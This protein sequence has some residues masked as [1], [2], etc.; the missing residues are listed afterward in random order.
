MFTKTQLLKT[1]KANGFKGTDEQAA[2]WIKKN[3]DIRDADGNAVDVDA[4]FARKT[5]TVTADA[6]EVVKV[7]DG[8]T[9]AEGEMETES[10]AK[11]ITDDEAAD[12]KRLKAKETAELRAKNAGSTGA[13]VAKGAA[14]ERF[15][16]GNTATKAYNRKAKSGRDTA[17]PIL[18]AFSDADTAH[19]FGEWVQSDVLRTKTSHVTASNTLGGALVP[20][21]F[22]PDLIDLKEQYGVARKLVPFIQISGHEAVLPRR[23]S[24][25]TVYSPQEGSAIT[26]SNM[27]FDNVTVN[28][29]EMAVLASASKALVQESAI[30]IG[31]TVANN[32]AW[33]FSE[34]EDDIFFNGDGSSAYFGMTGL[35]QAFQ[36][37][38]V[39]GGGTWAT[40]ASNQAGIVVGSGNLFSEIVLTDMESVV[41]LLPEFAEN[42]N[43][44][45]VASKPAWANV[46]VRLAYGVSGNRITDIQSGPQKSFMG[47][48]VQT[49][50]K[51]ARSD[52]NSQFI[53]YFGNFAQ[54][55]KAAETRGSMEIAVST[56]RYFDSG[57]IAFRGLQRVGLTVHDVGNYNSTAASRVPGP[58]IGLLSAA[59]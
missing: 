7:N 36:N 20:T 15:N 55:I 32:I 43:V 5:V 8:S 52:A 58:I 34:K 35:A 44:Q 23:T 56:E 21:E 49:A 2:D 59:S 37:S 42:G 9:P 18:T 25:L 29:K 46:F 54:G 45:W 22:L 24:N 38:V 27:A 53:T 26:E 48:S 16:I 6:G 13:L 33:A 30:D 39:N 12:Y 3:L 19:K 1:A 14:P 50:Q 51:M 31:N 47:Y 4:V 11:S 28:T 57:L 17:G 40:N 10:D 41:G